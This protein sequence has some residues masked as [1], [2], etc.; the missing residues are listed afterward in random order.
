[1]INYFIV[2]NELSQDVRE[3]L[4]AW[5]SAKG[6]YTILNLA[7]IEA[8]KMEEIGYKNVTVFKHDE[9]D[10]YDKV[11]TRCVDWNYVKKISSNNI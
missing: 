1:M 3:T 8:K 10:P 11:M 7:K 5:A 4:G 9:Y 2:F 6:H